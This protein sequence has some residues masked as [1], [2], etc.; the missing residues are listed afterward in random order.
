VNEE[1]LAQRKIVEEELRN[2][3][4]EDLEEF[5][6]ELAQQEKQFKSIGSQM[7]H[8]RRIKDKANAAREAAQQAND[9]LLSDVASQRGQ[10]AG[11]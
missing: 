3:L 11:K 1:D 5:K 6:E 8:M 4:E 2:K 9:N 10:G 7:E